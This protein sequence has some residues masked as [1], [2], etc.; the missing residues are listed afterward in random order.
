MAVKSSLSNTEDLDRMLKTLFQTMAQ[1]NA[2]MA[3]GQ[4]QVLEV[5]MNYA[6]SQMQHLDVLAGET[7]ATISELRASVV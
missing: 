5:T 4:E 2:E 6:K 7:G 1:G 3:A